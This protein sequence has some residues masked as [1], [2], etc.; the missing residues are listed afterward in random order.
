MAENRTTKSYSKS[1]VGHRP[2]VPVERS[3]SVGRG[4]D[5]HEVLI[6]H[7]CLLP[8]IVLNHLT[9]TM[10]LGAPWPKTLT[11]LDLPLTTLTGSFEVAA[12]LTGLES[13][14]L[15]VC[16]SLWHDK[17]VQLLLQKDAQA[18]IG[19]V[20]TQMSQLFLL[21]LFSYSTDYYMKYSRFRLMYVIVVVVCTKTD[22]LSTP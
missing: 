12:D 4:Q 9:I 1:P 10:L 11:C 14:E 8:M 15:E 22:I 7:F 20:H 6:D 16:L 13:L 3:S 21:Y 19:T 18:R 17:T 5:G 2:I